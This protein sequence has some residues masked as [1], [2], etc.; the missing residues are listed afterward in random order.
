MM[1][2]PHGDTS[3]CSATQAKNQKPSPHPLDHQLWTT[4]LPKQL[5]GPASLSILTNAAF[6][7][8]LLSPTEILQ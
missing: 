3:T 2:I 5:S 8:P 7:Q 4:L 1:K 6:M